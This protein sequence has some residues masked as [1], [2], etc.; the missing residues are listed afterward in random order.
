MAEF[1]EKTDSTYQTYMEV[2]KRNSVETRED[3]TEDPFEAFFNAN[4]N[5]NKLALEMTDLCR[6][7]FISMTGDNQLIR[8]IETTKSRLSA[9]L[10]KVFFI[11]AK[12]QSNGKSMAMNYRMNVDAHRPENAL[13][14]SFAF[15]MI[16]ETNRLLWS[17]MKD[18]WIC[19]EG[20]LLFKMKEARVIM[21]KF[22]RKEKIINTLMFNRLGFLFSEIREIIISMDKREKSQR[23][24]PAENKINRTGQKVVKKGN[25]DM[26]QYQ[27][28]GF[29]KEVQKMRKEPQYS[30]I[31]Q[32]MKAVAAVLKDRAHCSNFGKHVAYEAKDRGF[33][34]QQQLEALAIRVLQKYVYRSATVWRSHA[35]HTI[36]EIAKEALTFSQRL[37][38]RKEL[39]DDE[40]E[41]EV[42]KK[43]LNNKSTFMETV[44]KQ[45]RV[46]GL[47]NSVE[48]ITAV[49]FEELCH[50]LRWPMESL[51][52]NEY[53]R[54]CIQ[55]FA[56]DARTEF[57]KKERMMIE[58]QRKTR[59][60]KRDIDEGKEKAFAEL[61]EKC[62][63]LKYRSNLIDTVVDRVAAR[64]LLPTEARKILVE[65]LNERWKE[66]K[67]GGVLSLQIEAMIAKLVKDAEKEFE[68]KFLN[69]KS[70]NKDEKEAEDHKRPGNDDTKTTTPVITPICKERVLQSEKKVRI[71]RS[72]DV[73]RR[74]NTFTGGEKILKRLK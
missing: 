33:A 25:N 39:K 74:R 61:T 18:E 52:N 2:K 26:T 30:G 71:S 17:M 31:N 1:V 56:T 49:T 47:E 72:V 9:L 36:T 58:E 54:K 51:V 55:E 21:G 64:H 3:T 70:E 41:R 7:K 11:I 27:I 12:E 35:Q 14:I 24:N 8:T 50:Q 23:I 67:F 40:I 53:V 16:V 48:S 37:P 59:K 4:L 57:F 46:I 63:K 28:P 44:F 10:N 65:E 62:E 66:G 42:K 43:V 32:K 5:V 69:K 19:K 45:F 34:D 22:F 60:S 6:E 73:I 13:T 20:K 38:E 68:R 15:P 29:R